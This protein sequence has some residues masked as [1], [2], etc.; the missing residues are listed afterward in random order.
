MSVS[1]RRGRVCLT[2]CVCAALERRQTRVQMFSCLLSSPGSPFLVTGNTGKVRE[3]WHRGVAAI[4]ESFDTAFY[5]EAVVPSLGPCAECGMKYRCWSL[6]Q[7][8]TSGRSR[9]RSD[10]AMLTYADG[11][12]AFNARPRVPIIVQSSSFFYVHF[13]T[14][15]FTHKTGSGASMIPVKQTVCAV[16]PS[17]YNHR[18]QVADVP[19]DPLKCRG[20]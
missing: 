16:V 2:L 20:V 14:G 17:T 6:P 11:T 18:V 10:S 12:D 15:V 4:L 3:R 8:H 5:R 9:S 1:A 19:L 7:A 13:L